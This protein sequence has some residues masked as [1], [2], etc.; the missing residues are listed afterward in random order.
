[1]TNTLRDSRVQTV[2]DRLFA[3]A[4]HDDDRFARLKPEL[5]FQPGAA[6]AQQL[7]DTAAE[8]LMPVSRSGGELLY[9]LV[10]AI[11]PSTVVEFGTSFG[12]STLYLAAAVRDNGVG[13]VIGTELSEAKL[14][15][16]RANLAA[17]G[18]ADLVEI[19]AGDARQTLSDLDGPIGLLLLDGWKD[20][21]LPILRLLEPQLP[22]G[23]MVVAD[24]TTFVSLGEYLR[25]VRDPENGYQSVAFPVEDGMELSCRV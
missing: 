25:Y 13:R 3:D 20:L 24:D 23:A 4:E 14:A 18:V 15:A 12:I 1:V 5:N 11:R 8:I 10:R 21:C 6:S 7:S 9:T 22:A 19:R 17:A 16:A 2:L